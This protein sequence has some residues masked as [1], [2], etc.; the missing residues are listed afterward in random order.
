M[1]W[2]PT[3]RCASIKQ[4]RTV[5]GG[6]IAICVLGAHETMCINQTAKGPTKFKLP[7]VRCFTTIDHIQGP[8]ISLVSE[9]S[10]EKP[11]PIWSEPECWKPIFD[12]KSSQE[13]D[14]GTIYCWWSKKRAR[15]WYLRCWSITSS[16]KGHGRHQAHR[17]TPWNA[18][19]NI[20][21]KGI[22]SF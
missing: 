4:E 5:H 11:T 20:W 10:P 1:F 12:P 6:L 19:G 15:S 17:T 16:S 7:R 18:D 13:T 22:P 14:A 2:V 8:H 9:E 3:R 21:A